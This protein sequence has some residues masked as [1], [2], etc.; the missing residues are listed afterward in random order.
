[1]NIGNWIIVAFVLFTAFIA[2]LVVI[3]MRQEVSL[4]SQSYYQDE[5]AYQDQIDRQ[6]NTLEL[7]HK[8]TVSLDNRLLVLQFDQR[9]DIAE[10]VLNIFC[11]SDAKMDRR[12]KLD[13][14]RQMQQFD[15][16]QLNP[17]M[18]RVKLRWTMHD[19]EYYHEEII[20]L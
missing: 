14:G 11:P 4:V 9:S 6:R 1:M 5:L 13:A 10:G 18:Y 7:A 8:P 3:C 20:N 17:G 12:F 16:A 19:Q 2:T 15:L